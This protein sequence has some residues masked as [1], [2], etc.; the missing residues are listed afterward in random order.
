M[1]TL[2]SRWAD[3]DREGAWKAAQMTKIHRQKTQALSIVLSH[4]AKNDPRAA[5]ELHASLDNKALQ[6]ATLWGISSALISSDPQE[7]LKFLM[8]DGHSPWQM[9]QYENLFSARAGQDP[10]AAIAALAE[11]P[12]GNKQQAYQGI[13][14][15]LSQKDPEEAFA[16]AETIKNQQWRSQAIQAIV[17]NLAMSDPDTALSYLDSLPR[18]Q[19][20][21]NALSSIASV[22]MSSDPSRAMSWIESNLQGAE[23]HKAL[24]NLVQTLSHSDPQGAAELYDRF[25]SCAPTDEQQNEWIQGARNITSQWAAADPESAK[26]WVL[27]MPAGELRTS[28]LSQLVDS[29]GNTDVTGA[30]NFVLTL[31]AGA[32]RDQ[33]VSQLIYDV[34]HEEPESAFLWAESISDDSK[35]ENAVRKTIDHWKQDDPQAA[36]EAVQSANI[37]EKVRAN[38]LK[39][40]KD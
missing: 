30:A 19:A 5:K 14:Q 3:L 31:A 2:F 36:Q 40:I 29:W 35:R 13:V 7:A 8:E 9:E 33:A 15:A 16:F 37:S 34:R 28:S 6:Q 10:D 17:G 32:E 23:K 27:K 22:L 1:H 21:Q 38:L 24:G 25:A 26:D 4:I 18:G 12:P 20:R 39:R 11:L